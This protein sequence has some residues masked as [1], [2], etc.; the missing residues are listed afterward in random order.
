MLKALHAQHV[1]YNDIRVWCDRPFY[2]QTSSTIHG[3]SKDIRIDTVLSGKFRRYHTMPLHI[4]LL[5]L[6]TIVWPNIRDGFYFIAGFFQ[7]IAKLLIWRPDVVFCKGGFTSLPVGL[8]AQLL[9]IPVVLHDSDAHPGL[10]NRILAYGANHIATGAPAEKYGYP[11]HKVSYVGIPINERFRL[12]SQQ[13]RKMFKRSLGFSGDRPVVLITGGGLGAETLNN[14]AIAC[15]DQLLE[16]TDIILLTGTK[17][18]NEVADKLM[19]YSDDRLH[20]HAFVDDTMLETMAAADIVVARGGAT[21]LLEL[22]ALGATTVVVPNPYLTGG[23]QLKNV[24]AYEE[25]S[26][27]IVLHDNELAAK[28]KQLLRI[29]R[30]L[31]ADTK[32]Q[33][34]LSKAIHSFAQPDAAKK[35]ANKI[36]RASR[37]K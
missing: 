3:V 9:R 10:A 31:I 11:L 18:Y 6:K 8:A 4:Q 30:N 34:A 24:A 29:I 1:S 28:P 14:A 23:H 35:V 2:T 12:Y 20:V 36:C 16:V 32:Q 17:L 15:M 13:E 19:Q 37:N 26:A 5:R 21:T 27:V 33:A 22:A 7:S 25:K